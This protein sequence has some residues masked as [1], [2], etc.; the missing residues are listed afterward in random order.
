M[1]YLA[2]SQLFSSP[3][4]FH[5]IFTAFFIYFSFVPS[6]SC[7]FI[8]SLSHSLSLPPSR[9][10][11]PHSCT[12]ILLSYHIYYSPFSFFILFHSL[13]LFS[14]ASSSATGSGSG[15]GPSAS[16]SSNHGTGG[17]RATGGRRGRCVRSAYIFACRMCHRSTGRSHYIAVHL[18]CM[19]C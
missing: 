7:S 6:L 3:F 12:L 1:F 8:L 5:T 4:F 2:D 16:S 18:L 14:A 10:L 19:L 13:H 17:R 15:S 9:P 11:T